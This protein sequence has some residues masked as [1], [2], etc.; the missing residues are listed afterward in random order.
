MAEIGHVLNGALLVL[1]SL[2]ALN[3]TWHAHHGRFDRAAYWM[4]LAAFT[5]G[6]ANV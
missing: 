1:A 2:D 3:A 4:A 6:V 5:V